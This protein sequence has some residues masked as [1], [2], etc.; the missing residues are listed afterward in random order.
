MLAVTPSSGITTLSPGDSPMAIM[1]RSTRGSGVDRS[2]TKVTAASRPS[3]TF[4]TSCGF[5]PAA[6]DSRVSAVS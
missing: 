6:S 3:S 5:A 2:R 4:S 1:P